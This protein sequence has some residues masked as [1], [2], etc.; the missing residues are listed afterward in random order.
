[1]KIAFLVGQ[2]PSLSE[3]FVLDQIVGLIQQGHEVD[4]Y[5]SPPENKAQK[6]HPDI[7]G[8]QL[9]QRT[10]YHPSIPSNYIFRFLKGLSLLLFHLPK[11]PI[12]TLKT[13]N[14]RKYGKQAIALRLFF[15]VLPFLKLAPSRYDIIFCHF[16][17]NGVKGE[18][19]RELG[20]LQGKLCTVFHGFDLTGYLQQEGENVYNDLFQ[21][22]ELF[23]PISHRWQ[24]K[25]LELGCPS[26]KI[27]V[28]HMGINCE[29]FT[30]T[31]RQMPADGITR[32]VSVCRLV[33]KKGIE[34]GIRAIAQVKEQAPNVQYTI[35]GDGPLKSEL[36][37]L[38]ADLKVSETVQLVG[39]KQRDEVIEILNQSQIFLAP[40]VT[41]RNGDQ[42]G[43]PVAL[44]E[45]MAMGMPVVSTFHS[46]IPELVEDGISGYL[47]PERDVTGLADKISTLIRNSKLWK[48]IGQEGYQKVEKEFNNQWL[49]MSLCSLFRNLINDK[50][51]SNQTV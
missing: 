22:G 9:L 26:E 43:I 21:Q 2:F 50:E 23:L 46:G 36:E 48:E 39:W 37:A 20:L 31:P 12:T 30:F 7:E 27:Q 1:M 18:I 49:V 11:A 14:A 24:H 13:L 3:T 17:S 5:A 19:L 15:N 8:Y 38:I 44:M 10:F 47:T 40:S 16:G 4:I 32:L 33:E 42:E 35:I 25:L 28:H 6:A 29:K 45:A 51:V 34:Y 41:A